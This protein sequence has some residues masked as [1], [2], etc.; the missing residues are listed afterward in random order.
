M[1]DQFIPLDAPAITDF[2]LDTSE[3]SVGANTVQRE[4]MNIADPTVAAG[5]AKVVNADPTTEYGL[6]TRDPKL[7]EVVGTEDVANS[8]GAKVVRVGAVR[9]DADTSLVDADGDEAQLQVNAAGALKVEIFAGGDTHPISGTVTIQDGGNTITVDNGGVF[10]VQDATAQAS[11][12]VI[13][14]WD[15]TNRAA[16]NLIVGQ[17][18][19]AAGAGAV[20]ATVQRVT[21]ASD[22]PAVVAVQ[23]LDD[24]V[25]TDDNA[26]TPA[27]TK[28][29][30]AGFFADETS[31][32]SVDEGDGGAARMTLDRRQITVPQ[33]HAT[34]GCDIFRSLDLDETEEE[35]KGSAGTV[36]G[37]YIANRAAATTYV[38]FY[39]ATAASVVVGT[40]TPVLTLPIPG[41]TS[42]DVGANMLGGLGIKFDTAITVAAT[43]GV[44]DADTG[45]PAAND[46]IINLFYK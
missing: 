25:V 3:L 41:N 31:T 35:V 45:A 29:H 23:L 9:R 36:Y 2:K 38:K 18:G 14:D 26:F 34:G 15:E 42:D 13:D 33:P 10:A 1:A 5:L 30:M 46:L 28:V 7:V 12:S 32:D 44:A 8:A 43:T 24:A 19:V 16:V 21:L 37:W 11:L 6:V 40:T 39:N 17:A 22:D 20:G 27:T 4:R